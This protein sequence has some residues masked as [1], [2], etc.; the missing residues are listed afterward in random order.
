MRDVALRAGEEVVDAQDIVAALD[1]TIAQV[2]SEESGAAGDKRLVHLAIG[3]LQ[4]M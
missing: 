1:E 2:R 4:A 3:F